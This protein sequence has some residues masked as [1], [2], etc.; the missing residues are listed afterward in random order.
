[1]AKSP[2]PLARL[3][4]GWAAVEVALN[5]KKIPGTAEPVVSYAER[6]E[7]LSA[8]EVRWNDAAEALPRLRKS[9][10]SGRFQASVHQMELKLVEGLAYMPNLHIGAAL[11]AGE[12]IDDNER[13][14]MMDDT[15][16]R[17]AGLGRVVLSMPDRGEIAPVKHGLVSELACGAVGQCDE[18]SRYL[19][20]PASFRQDHNANRR[21]RSDYMAVTIA[22]RPF[23][24]PIQVTSKHGS[25]YQTGAR[26]CDVVAATDLVLGD[27]RSVS[28]TLDAFILSTEGRA[29]PDDEAGLVRLGSHLTSMLDAVNS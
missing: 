23:K 1:L 17:V 28:E 2:H 8:A 19:V 18:D 21:I 4:A 27:G 9:Q 13:R 15:K 11:H 12:T 22:P 26:V 5:R 14:L 10:T 29:D 3:A 20:V 25:P 7:A 16:R 24:T 6:L